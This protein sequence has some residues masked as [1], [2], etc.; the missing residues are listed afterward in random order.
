MP[1]MLSDIPEA[2]EA[3]ERATLAAVPPDTVEEVGGWLLALD[4]GTVGRAHS[5][6]PLAHVSPLPGLWREIAARYKAHALPPVFR[7]PQLPCFDT[8]RAEL[9]AHGYAARQPTLVQTQTGDIGALARLS[10]A[11]TVTLSDTFDAEAANVFLGEGFD[12]VDGAHRVRLLRRAVSA[13]HAN[14]RVDGRVVAVGSACFASGWMGV[15]GMRTLP[16]HRGQGLASQLLAAF[17]ATALARGVH[18]VFLQVDASSLALPLYRRAGFSPAWTY[19]YW[20]QPGA[21]LA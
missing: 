6:V 8:L 12:P 14:V 16:A 7:L 11:R 10:D 1:S 15:H 5:A 19:A 17:G 4:R 18:N 2:V 9:A 3:I 20:R 13:V 21:A